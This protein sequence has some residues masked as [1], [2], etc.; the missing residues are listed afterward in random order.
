METYRFGCAN[1][2]WY[3]LGTIPA[4]IYHKCQLWLYEFLEVDWSKI[5]QFTELN[6]SK[7]TNK[8]KTLPVD[9]N[10]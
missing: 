6:I 4:K 9:R 1:P 8:Q 7:K 2:Y 10:L 3:F 5:A